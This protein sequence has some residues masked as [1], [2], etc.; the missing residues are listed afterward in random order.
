MK[1]RALLR[2]G[3]SSLMAMAAAPLLSRSTPSLAIDD[4]CP[5]EG[6]I[7]LCC[8]ENPYGPSPMARQAIQEASILGNR[9]PQAPIQALKEAIAEANGVSAEQVSPAGSILATSNLSR[10]EASL[11]EFAFVIKSSFLITKLY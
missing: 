11:E 8:N 2:A 5:P 6:L 9:Y 4:C 7:R 3:A 10:S 1:R